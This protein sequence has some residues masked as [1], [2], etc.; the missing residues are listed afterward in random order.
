MRDRILSTGLLVSNLVSLTV[1]CSSVPLGRPKIAPGVKTVTSIGG[2][3]MAIVAGFPGESQVTTTGGEER[4]SSPEGLISGRVVDA[5]GRPVANAE[6]RLA[7]GTTSMNRDLRVTTDVAGGFTLHGLRPG[8]RYTLIAEGEDGG[9]FLVGRGVA[10]AP[11]RRVRIRLVRAEDQEQEPESNETTPGSIERASNRRELGIEEEEAARSSPGN[12]VNLDDLPMPA[13]ADVYGASQPVVTRPKSVRTA[14]VQGWRASG[15]PGEMGFAPSPFDRPVAPS[16]SRKSVM[17][18]PI[19]E[20]ED[21]TNPL[22]PAIEREPA[23]S[24]IVVSGASEADELRPGTSAGDLFSGMTS[25]TS[26]PLPSGPPP[27]RPLGQLE[28]APSTGGRSS[29]PNAPEPTSGAAAPEPDPASPGEPA[30]Q[31]SDPTKSTSAPVADRSTTADLNPPPA[32]KPSPQPSAIPPGFVEAPPAP[33][34]EVETA[35]PVNHNPSEG[36]DPPPTTLMGSPPAASTTE[37]QAPMAEP[38]ILDSSPWPSSSPDQSGSQE[39]SKDHAKADSAE[40]SPGPAAPEAAPEASRAPTAASDSTPVAPPA[41]PVVPDGAD[42]IDP[43]S[44]EP[45]APPASS[46]DPPSVQSATRD[47]SETTRDSNPSPVV[48]PPAAPAVGTDPPSVDETAEP[49][50]PPPQALAVPPTRP[51]WSELTAKSHLKSAELPARDLHTRGELTGERIAASERAR[52]IDPPSMI[53]RPAAPSDAKI[54]NASC[55]FDARHR[56]VVDFV[57]P[58]LQGRPVRLQD[59]DADFVLID[60]WGTWCG[61]C[62]NSIPHL[63]ELQKRYDPKRLRVLGVAY[64]QGPTREHAAKVAQSMRELGINYPVL[65]AEQDGKPCPLATA[66]KVGNYP[67]MILLDRHGRILWRETGSNPM[68]LGRLDRVVAANTQSKVVRR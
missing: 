44:N 21:E 4:R 57:L 55:Q 53:R 50:I 51:T 28:M 3:P 20:D 2:K 36:N 7:D 17:G 31:L 34:T 60:F 1:G 30:T 15:S 49:P 64:E 66:L 18:L 25:A 11:D 58:D 19:E 33:S 41:D 6:V 48:A 61:P 39:I 52:A 16:G 46:N 40:K 12:R 68:T 67:T 22:P 13:E 32:S 43:P 63:V 10:S 62:R 26:A 14:S 65:L 38:P 56:R 27:D 47:T 45:V 8:K 35:A 59:L 24:A 9:E 23:T 37:Q 42:A 5:R 54:V 29:E